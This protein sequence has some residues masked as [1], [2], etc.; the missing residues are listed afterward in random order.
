[1]YKMILS[2]LLV[3]SCL[4]VYAGPE[5]DALSTC[6]ADST[7]GRERK[8][9]ARWIFV[10]ISAHPEIRDIS[11]VSA[12]KRDKSNKAMAALVTRLLTED[13]VTPAKAAIKAGNDGFTASFRVLGQL[14]MQELMSD[15]NVSASIAEY[16]Q[17]L[18]RKKLDASLAVK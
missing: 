10:A 6:L 13:C 2:V 17:H 5:S 16:A 9:L 8:E 15:P 7:S 18:D 12:P 3:L 1:M 4:P 11:N 14:A